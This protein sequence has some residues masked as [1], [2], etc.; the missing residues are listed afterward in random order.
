MNIC[1]GTRGSHEEIVY[2]GRNCPLCAAEDALNDAYN[3]ISELEEELK[4]R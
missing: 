2:E 3:K 4:S 1:E